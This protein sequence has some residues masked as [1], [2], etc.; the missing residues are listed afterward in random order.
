MGLKF[1]GI[2]LA[3]NEDNA[4]ETL[5]LDGADISRLH[6]IRDEHGEDTNFH[7]VGAVKLAKKIYSEKD[8]EDEKQLRC[9]KHAKVPFVYVESELAD[10][11]E[12]PNAIASAGLIKFTQRPDIPLNVGLSV[13]GGILER[14]TLDGL[15][16]EDKASGKNL[17]KTVALDLALTV[18]PCNPKCVIFLEND[19]QKSIMTAKAPAN[20]ADLL[21]KSQDAHSIHE[22]KDFRLLMKLDKLKKSLKDYFSAFTDMKCHSCSKPVR[23]FKSSNSVPN[24]CD[25][26]RG[27]FSMMS[28]W[29]AMNK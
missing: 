26:C 19:L 21:L 17:I 5:H 8:C 12:H 15:I 22:N 2:G 24:R 14:R 20:Y 9:W 16:T 4:G 6:G 3:Q 18:K 29:K 10:D 1:Y 27:A 28:I 25:G 23:F 13:D 11:T 7:R